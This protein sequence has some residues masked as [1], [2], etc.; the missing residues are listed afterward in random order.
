MVYLYISQLCVPRSPISASLIS[1]SEVVVPL[2][3]SPSQWM[4]FFFFF[5]GFS[6][7]FSFVY[8]Y[9]RVKIALWWALMAA[10]LSIDFASQ[11]S[12]LGFI[13]LSLICRF[14]I[15]G[16]GI[17]RSNE[18]ARCVE[19]QMGLTVCLRV[20]FMASLDHKIVLFKI[21]AHQTMC[22]SKVPINLKTNILKE[23]KRLISANVTRSFPTSSYVIYPLIKGVLRHIRVGR[24]PRR[25]HMRVYIL[26]YLQQIACLVAKTSREYKKKI[27]S[28]KQASVPGGKWWVVSTKWPLAVAG[29]CWTAPSAHHQRG[30]TQGPTLIKYM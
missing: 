10:Q 6:H 22:Y 9:L 12:F 26:S 20:L 21:K 5:L 28:Q 15:G 17:D 2:W 8:L 3:S 30:H 16:I 18:P 23:H 24:Q 1:V 25:R 11:F 7:F 4:I 13:L 27:N 29:R 19:Y 14:G